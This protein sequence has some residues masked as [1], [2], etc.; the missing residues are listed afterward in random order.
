MVGMQNIMWSWSLKDPSDRSG[1][2]R[3]SAEARKCQRTVKIDLTLLA[4]R[5]RLRGAA[6]EAR[7][8]ASWT[9]RMVH[10]GWNDRRKE[11][12]RR[13]QTLPKE[14]LTLEAGSGVQLGESVESV[15][16]Q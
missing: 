15:A 7:C 12:R 9:L 8:I 13:E 4:N 14:V 2:I 11:G 10:D 1:L 16:T 5:S 6:R 3:T